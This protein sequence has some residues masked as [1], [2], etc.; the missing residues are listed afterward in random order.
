VI[1]PLSETDLVPYQVSLPVGE[2]VLVLSPHPD[3][4]T[5]G[6]GGTLRLLADAGKKIKV[7]I[8]TGGEK[9]DPANANALSYKKRR[10]RETVKALKILGVAD[11]RFLGFPDRGLS[12]N[13]DTAAE[14][15]R[16]ITKD[17]L[18]GVIY[19]TSPIEVH[20][21]HRIA[22][23]IA[24]A[25]KREMPELRCLFYEVVTPL[26]PSIF[27]DITKSFR[28]KEKAM[29]CY[30]SQLRITDYLRLMTALSTYRS[31]TLGRGVKFAEAFWELS[32]IVSAES[33][34]RWLSYET[35][36]LL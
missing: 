28:Y 21:D 19:C 3:D 33:I 7:L 23:E 24:V 22:A 30:K 34:R 5:L 26:R 32:G 18:P 9:A 27:V 36:F 13:E 25:L 4:E 14:A 10:E 29:K 11:F 6:M 16:T 31:F 15:V 17:F 8:L 12:E 35:P 2:R 1:S 20:P